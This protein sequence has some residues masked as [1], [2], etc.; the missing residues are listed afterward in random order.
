MLAATD[1]IYNLS[2]EQH[3]PQ[4]L[5]T[6]NALTGLLGLAQWHKTF[7]QYGETAEAALEHIEKQFGKLADEAKEQ[8][9]KDRI[10]HK[11]ELKEHVK[12]YQKELEGRETVL[13]N[14]IK[15]WNR[16]YTLLKERISV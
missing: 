11:D 10:S 1:N 15:E 9:R 4:S 8:S 12:N 16:K 5:K 7:S 13:G 6:I 2:S 14:E 3:P